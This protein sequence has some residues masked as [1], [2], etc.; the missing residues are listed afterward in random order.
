M[1]LKGIT[2]CTVENY[3]YFEH[4]YRLLFTQCYSIQK[5]ILLFKNIVHYVDHHGLSLQICNY[6]VILSAI[7]GS[8][9]Q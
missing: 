9:P 5:D 2:I 4:S 1:H 6:T 7:G 8:N 3:Y